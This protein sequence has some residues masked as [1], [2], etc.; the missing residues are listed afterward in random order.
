VRTDS[1]A[2]R[3]RSQSSAAIS[4][5]GRHWFLLNASPDVRDQLL[6]L[7]V[8]APGRI[9]C[10]PIEAVL[11]TDAELDHSLGI[12]L[13]REAGRL[14]LCATASVRA[15][16]ETESR[17][18]PVTR[19]FAEI[20]MTELP[21]DRTVSL[22]LNDGSPSGLTLLAIPLA[23]SAPRFASSAS[24]GHT[25]GFV[26]HDQQ[27]GTA[28]GFFPG[29]GD[30]PDGLLA[31]LADLDVVLFDGTFWTD[32]ELILL[33]IGSRTA[34]ELD[35]MPVSGP[36]GSLERLAAL[37]CPHRIYTHINNTNPMLLECGPEH[38]AV[39][40]AGLRVG[41]DGLRLEV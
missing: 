16:L 24:E 37:R 39:T 6:G 33:G 36:G 22:Q 1:R 15:V 38:V 8:P 34:R 7:P 35:H 29:C 13:L 25:V 11:L 17:L 27:R 4:A 28:L 21:L 30:L 32:D 41:F 10:V 9:R 19:A 14:R 12:A 3:P 40:R 20:S 26:I 2:A 23:G 18:V 5:D 31:R